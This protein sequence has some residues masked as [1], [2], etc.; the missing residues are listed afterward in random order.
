[1]NP[2]D[3]LRSIIAGNGLDAEQVIGH[4]NTCE[5]YDHLFNAVCWEKRSVKLKLLDGNLI[6]T[7]FPFLFQE[8]ETRYFDQI[9]GR[10]NQFDAGDPLQ[11]YG[12]LRLRA[13]GDQNGIEPDTLFINPRVPCN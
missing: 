13:I 4:G 10:M 1:M 7:E 12:S 11:S 9:I 6:V 3:F 2:A 8:I 5:E